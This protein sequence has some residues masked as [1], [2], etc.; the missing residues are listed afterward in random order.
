MK[1]NRW[2]HMLILWIINTA[3]ILWLKPNIMSKHYRRLLFVFDD[4]LTKM[5]HLI[6][7]NHNVLFFFWSQSLIKSKLFICKY[8][9]R[10]LLSFIKLLIDQYYWIY[11][12][13][14]S[15]LS[16]LYLNMI[17]DI[18]SFVSLFDSIPYPTNIK[19]I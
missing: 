1:Q 3:F 12:S 15:I 9:F 2:K 17:V 4:V 10:L 19:P 6:F 7:A 14:I 13:S 16:C 11:L 8:I 5:S 18:F